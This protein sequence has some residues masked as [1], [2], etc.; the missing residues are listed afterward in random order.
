MGYYKR[1]VQGRGEVGSEAGTEGDGDKMS[2]VWARLAALREKGRIDSYLCMVEGQHVMMCLLVLDLFHV[3]AVS[4]EMMVV[5][6]M[7]GR[8]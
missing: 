2:G 4:F 3:C 7:S 5:Q 6:V 8:I 1:L